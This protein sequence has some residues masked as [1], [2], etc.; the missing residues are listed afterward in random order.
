[1]GGRREVIRGKARPES[2]VEQAEDKYEKGERMKKLTKTILKR[3]IW[4]GRGTATVMGLA[5]LLALTVGLASTALAG[6]GVGARFDLGKTNAVD[7]ASRLVG[8]VNWPVLTV[9]NN[10]TVLGATALDLQVEPTKDPM[11][12]NS[13]AKVDNLNADRL[14][15]FN[16]SDF[17]TESDRDAFLPSSGKAND[18][19]LL[20]GRD[21]TSFVPTKTYQVT[22]QRTGAGGGSPEQR[23]PK[24]DQGD[25]VLNGGFSIGG[26]VPD[27]GVALMDE[28]PSLVDNTWLVQVEDVGSPSFMAGIVIC[29]DLPPLRQ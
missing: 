23:N 26:F 20:D 12:V 29:A 4:L 16:S 6:T 5:M 22:D 14:D 17:L 3:T 24:C 27:S 28:R 25:V 10:S 7:T 15:N 2:A 11:K 8:N 18:A 13:S 1:V 21:S 9:D 19:N